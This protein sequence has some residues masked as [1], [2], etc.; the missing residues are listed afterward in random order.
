MDGLP[1]LTDRSGSYQV[2]R[3]RRMLWGVTSDGFWGASVERDLRQVYL[4]EAH[5]PNSNL[6]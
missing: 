1:A 2:L 4:S 5:T 6:I 3:Q